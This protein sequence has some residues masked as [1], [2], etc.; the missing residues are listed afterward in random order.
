MGGY[1]S[2]FVIRHSSFVIRHSSLKKTTPVQ[3][4]R[5]RTGVLKYIMVWIT[6]YFDSAVAEALSEVG[7]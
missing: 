4:S 1:Y 2:P 6:A 5:S 3:S 7:L